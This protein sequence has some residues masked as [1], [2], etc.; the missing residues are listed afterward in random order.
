MFIHLILSHREDFHTFYDKVNYSPSESESNLSLGQLTDEINSYFNN[1]SLKPN[2][3]NYG[4]RVLNVVFSNGQGQYVVRGSYMPQA[5][6]SFSQ[7]WSGIINQA[8]FF[9]F[10]D[11]NRQ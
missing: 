4:W 11:R 8:P 6:E 3:L 1:L 10:V 5:G 9:L 7:P 2:S